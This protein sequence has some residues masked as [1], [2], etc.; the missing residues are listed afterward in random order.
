MAR[1]PDGPPLLIGHDEYYGAYAAALGLADSRVPVFVRR[2][3]DLGEDLLVEYRRSHVVRSSEVPAP[4]IALTVCGGWASPTPD[5]Y[6]FDD[7]TTSPNIRSVHERL[8][9]YRLLL[10]DGVIVHDEI[11]GIGGRATSGVLG[12]MFTI[13]GDAHAHQSRMAFAADG[14]QL[15]RA[16]ARKGWISKSQTVMVTNDGRATPNVPSDRADLAALAQV[17]ELPVNVSY[18]PFS[19]TPGVSLTTP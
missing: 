19:C 5:R 2:A 17:I 12:V 4:D 18:V 10:F 13:L 9:S 11:T 16:T 8:N 15:T 6:E 1:A 14:T 7:T 3:R